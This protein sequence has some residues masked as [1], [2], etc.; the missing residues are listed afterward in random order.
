[1]VANA[2][3]KA[4]FRLKTALAAAKFCSKTSE[5]PNKCLRIHKCVRQMSYEQNVIKPSKFKYALG[6]K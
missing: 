1:M 5:I 4:E 2:D 3:K 6:L